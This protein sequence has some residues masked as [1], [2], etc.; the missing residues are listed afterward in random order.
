MLLVL[1]LIA[2]TTSHVGLIIAIPTAVVG[3]GLASAIE[4]GQDELFL[5][6]V[7]GGNFQQLPCC[8]LGLTPERMDEHLA[9]GATGEGID[10]G[11]CRRNM[12]GSPPRGV[13]VVVDNR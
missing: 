1:L 13:P 12:V 9:G 2:V 10:D 4:V 8:S 6:G 7:L 3:V 11:H 5:C